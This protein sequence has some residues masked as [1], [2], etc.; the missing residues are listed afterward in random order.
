M[1]RG[2]MFFRELG[3]QIGMKKSQVVIIGGLRQQR[4]HQHGQYRDSFSSINIG[5][6]DNGFDASHEDLNIN[7]F[8][9]AVNNAEHPDTHV[10]GIIGAINDNKIGITGVLDKVDLYGVDCY[11]ASK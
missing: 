11:A 4:F 5:F 6:V 10:A 7:V 1:I 2:K 9:D 3:V 8:N